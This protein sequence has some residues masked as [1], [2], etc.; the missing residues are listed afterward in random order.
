MPGWSED[1]VTRRVVGTFL[2]NSNVAGSG[3]ISFYP[4]T[5]VYDPDDSVVISS[6]ITYT[7]DATGSFTAELPTTDNPL[8]TPTGWA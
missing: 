6:P 1:V 2:T 7:L 8:L 4:T 5:T 3:T